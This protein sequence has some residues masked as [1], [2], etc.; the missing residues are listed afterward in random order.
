[1]RS[2]FKILIKAAVLTAVIAGIGAYFYFT[3]VALADEDKADLI[4]TGVYPEGLKIWDTEVGGLTY[5]QA[6]TL[7]KRKE[8]ETAK[9]TV[10]TLTHNETVFTVGPEK[11]DIRFDTDE[12]LKNALTIAK[13]GTYIER[14]TKEERAASLNL[15]VKCTVNPTTA[16]GRAIEAVKV[17]KK[18][19]SNAKMEFKPLERSFTY[20]KEEHGLKIDSSKLSALVKEAA[21]ERDFTPIEVPVIDV[22]PDITEQMLRDVT[23]KRA[24]FT[25]SFADSPYNDKNRVYNINKC[26][27]IINSSKKTT[28]VPGEV[29][30]L[31]EVLGDR[32]SKGGWKDAPGYVGGRSEDQPG[33]GVCQI[34]TTLYCA[35]LSADLEV[36][37]RVN[38][39]IPVGYSKKGLDAT[40]STGGPDLKIKNNTSSNIYLC[41][42]IGSDSKV[43]FEIYGEPFNGFTSISLNSVKIKDIE[44][45]DEMKITVD[46]SY[47]ADYE[48]VYIKRRTGSFWR[49]YKV[50]KNG[51]KEI[52][53][54]E[55]YTSTYKA[56]PGETIVGTS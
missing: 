3:P 39:S 56:Y 29:F 28:L 1:M 14:K 8:E 44:P 32:T 4:N 38:H 51:D 53:R 17:L 43:T 46:E 16:A 35:A 21:L 15:P 23:V 18:D 27:D 42:W 9:N 47:P 22:Q 52:N 5:E 30:S 40:I 45:E 19:A 24:S 2:S 20:T 10:F 6:K 50:Y 34:S 54:V 25:T 36:T 7:L 37:D 41:A 33:G 49:T 55:T 31:N 11:L 12:V 13:E 48:Q 26:V